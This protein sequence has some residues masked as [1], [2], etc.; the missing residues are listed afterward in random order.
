MWHKGT[1]R[2][3]LILALAG[4]VGAL[5]ETD[6]RRIGGSAFEW[7]LASPA[8]GPVERV[9]FSGDGSTLYARTHSG[10][11]LKTSDFENWESAPGVSDPAPLPAPPVARVPDQ[12]ARLVTT[13]SAVFALGRQVFRSEDGGRAWDN[14]TAYKSQS[15]IGGGQHDVAVWPGNPAQ[16]VVAN[17]FGVWRSMD[18]GLSWTGLNQMLPNLGVHRILTAASGAAVQVQVGSTVLELPPGSSVWIP[19]PAAALQSE[20]AQLQRYASSVGT[21]ELNAELTTSA[22]AGD[23]VYAGSAD[24]RIWKSVDG[25][26]TFER[27]AMP[28]GTA[29]EAVERIFVDP[30]QP[31]VAL[32]ALSGTGPHVLRTINGGEFW[33]VL[34]ANLPATASAYGIAAERSAGAVYVATEKG[35]YYAVTDLEAASSPADVKW[36]NLS[37]KLPGARATDVRLDPAGVQVYAAV[38]GY[39]VYATAAPHRLRSLRIVN[40]ADF[41][42]R[43]AAPGSLLSV[44]G[45]RLSGVRAGN[46]EYPVL[47]ASDT[48]SQIQVPFEA[49]GPE[50]VLELETALEKVTRRLAVQPVSPAILVPEGVP[51]IYDADSGMPL[52]ART[53]AHSGTRI[54]IIATGMGKVQPNWPTGL[55]APLENPPAVVAS[56]RAYLDR[57]PVEVTRATLAPGFVG[58]YL[59]EVQL[60]TIANF[61]DA[62]LY[63]SAGG[64]DSNR[65]RIVIEP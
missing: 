31:R 18:G 56:V 62:E 21:L 3:L 38:D 16:L 36:T 6:W 14:L 39:G 48:A 47:V 15:V 11:V 1:A 50:V 5:A 30:T 23:T 43:P 52:D 34:D 13:A 42:T 64:Q 9:W 53:R 60:P 37:E 25:G 24:G 2:R 58:F 8:T 19:A 65:V 45:G 10:K 44:I 49:V 61:G 33:D 57:T 27:T 40:A 29:G 12:G 35:V 51:A 54:Q 4:A 63:I 20:A 41:S 46:L 26:R 28:A 7:R 55:A 32:A 59:I 22:A 17:D